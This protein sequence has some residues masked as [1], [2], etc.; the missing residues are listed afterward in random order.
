MTA[1]E[2]Y[3]ASLIELNKLEAPSILLE[4]FNY[5]LNK[6]IQQ[7]VNKK[8]NIYDINQQTTDDLRILKDSAKLVAVKSTLG[9]NSV[10]SEDSLYGAMYEIELPDNYLHLLNCVCNF[11]VKKN[12]KC[13][14]ANSYVQFGAKRLT[15]DL[16]SQIINN[17]YMRPSYKRP[18]YYLKSV[19]ETGDSA[20]NLLDIKTSSKKS[21]VY[22]EIRYGKDDSL[23]ELENVYVDYLKTPEFITL[24]QEQIDLVEDTSQEIEF[25]N[26]ICYEIIN[27][28]VKLLLENSSDQR[29]QT[30]L[31]INQTIANPVQQQSQQQSK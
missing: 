26:Y 19:T 1:R 13:Y 8:Y 21:K 20:F 6:A 28:L 31:A 24:T 3:E 5:L 18:Y 12:F 11:K 7:Y 17:F 10:T 2:I 4:D 15:A 30:N 22:L 23:F 14:N 25:S 27:E 9:G 29:L 16:W